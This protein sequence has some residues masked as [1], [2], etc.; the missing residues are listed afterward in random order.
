MLLPL[1]V[2]GSLKWVPSQHLLLFKQNLLSEARQNLCAAQLQDTPFSLQS[3]SGVIKALP[4][5]QIQLTT[6]FCIVHE[7]RII[8]TFF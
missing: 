5:G 3:T 2:I 6:W 8:F 4:A 1:L 7:L